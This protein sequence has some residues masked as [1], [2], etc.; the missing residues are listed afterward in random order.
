MRPKRGKNR[1]D[2]KKNTN[3]KITKTPKIFR[4]PI[5]NLKSTHKISRVKIKSSIN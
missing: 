1:N 2:A 3:P 4:R 5:P